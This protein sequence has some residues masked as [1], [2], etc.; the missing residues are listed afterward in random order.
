MKTLVFI[1]FDDNARLQ[2][3]Q[4]N[5]L[6]IGDIERQEKKTS[7]DKEILKLWKKAQIGDELTSTVIK[8][9]FI[10]CLNLPKK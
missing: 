4:Y 6:V 10:F 7:Y 3:A 2:R 9:N 8:D 1:F 5:A